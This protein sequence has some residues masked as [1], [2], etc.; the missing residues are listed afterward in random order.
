M[1]S[2]PASDSPM[3]RTLPSAHQVGHSADGVLDRSVRVDPM[4]VVQVDVV[5]A[6]PL[7]GAL[8]GGA[9]VRRAA[10][11]HAGPASGVRHQ[12]ELRRHHDLIAATLDRPP[13]QFLVEEGSVDLG[14]VEVGDAQIQRPVDGADRLGVA[15]LTGV[16]VAG[17]RHSAQADPGDVQLAQ[18][19]VFHQLLQ[20]SISL[21]SR[22]SWAWSRVGVVQYQTAHSTIRMLA[23]S[24]RAPCTVILAKSLS[25]S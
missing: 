11:D 20:F 19:D 15:A 8:D 3:W 2:T 6:E 4:L 13:D 1:V 18:R 14:G 21:V 12:A 22:R 23:S 25:I 9:D 17:H 7:Q 5:S 10:V 24:I 16:V